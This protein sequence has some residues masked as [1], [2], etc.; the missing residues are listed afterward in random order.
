M[1]DGLQHTLV[2][3]F[4][5]RHELDTQ[6]E[7]SWLSSHT[8]PMLNTEAA[9]RGSRFA[10][11]ILDAGLEGKQRVRGHDLRLNLELIDKARP[12]LIIILGKEYGE[13]NHRGLDE[14][15]QTIC[16]N[17]DVAETYGC[18]WVQRGKA[19]AC[20]ILE[21]GAL[22]GVL[23]HHTDPQGSASGSEHTYVYVRD[24]AGAALEA[25]AEDISARTLRDGKMKVLVESLAEAATLK[26]YSSLEE[27]GDM[28]LQDWRS[29]LGEVC[30]PQGTPAPR[31]G[32]PSPEYVPT[33]R[34]EQLHRVLDELCGCVLQGSTQQ[35]QPQS[36][37]IA[38]IVGPHG[39]GKSE[40]I[41]GW[42]AKQQPVASHVVLKYINVPCSSCV[43]MQDKVL[44]AATEAF[45]SPFAWDDPLRTAGTVFAASLHLA[46]AVL[47]VDGVDRLDDLSWIPQVI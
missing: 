38:V 30:P 24:D 29:V 28:V 3:P 39:S 25:A 40:A 20:S 34:T 27:L 26:R 12:F 5:L 37:Q 43:G 44:Q 7:L 13:Y 47:I 33:T 21:L 8:F 23:K 22:H 18:G 16:D 42:V 36:G 1:P 45:L 35:Q 32:L 2:N 11:I 6:A 41:S 4:V 10:P 9:T 19:G 15:P 17:W 46:P 31:A 14:P